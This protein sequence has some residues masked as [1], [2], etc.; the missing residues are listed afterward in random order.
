MLH[1]QMY[2]QLRVKFTFQCYMSY[3]QQFKG[4]AEVGIS[5]SRAYSHFFSVRM[6]CYQLLSAWIH[7]GF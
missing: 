5:N 7:R 3:M 1:V 4:N 6:F 2:Y